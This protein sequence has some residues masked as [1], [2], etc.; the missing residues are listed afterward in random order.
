M[1][2]EGVSCSRLGAGLAFS[3]SSTGVIGIAFNSLK[4]E[5]ALGIVSF[6]AVIDFQIKFRDV[7]DGEQ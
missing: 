3:T 1:S 5:E 7:G 6:I 4:E 2:D